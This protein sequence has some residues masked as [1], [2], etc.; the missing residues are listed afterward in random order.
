VTDQHYLQKA[1]YPVIDNH[2]HLRESEPDPCIKAM[3]ATGVVQVVNLD[4]GWGNELKENIQKFEKKYPGRFLT[5]A[6]VDW[7]RID[8]PDFGIKAAAQLEADVRTGARGFRV[9]KTLG[10]TMRDES[11]EMVPVAAARLD[12]TWTN[13]AELKSPV[14]IQLRDRAA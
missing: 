10:L 14:V 3:D 5:Y 2:N 1:K 6:L 4:G 12:P 9:H 8:E 13:C 7:S 11:G